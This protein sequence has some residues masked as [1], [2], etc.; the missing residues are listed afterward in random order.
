MQDWHRGL[1]AYDTR[2]IAEGNSVVGNVACHNRPRT[3]ESVFAYRHPWI[4]DAASSDGGELLDT[5]LEKFPFTMNFGVLVVGECHTWSDEHVVLDSHTGWDENE[6]SDLAIVAYCHAFLD[7]DEGVDLG[8]LAD[9]AA[10]KVY[11]VKDSG[12]GRESRLFDNRVLRAFPH[13]AGISSAR[14]IWTCT[15]RS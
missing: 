4:D 15:V 11:L 13:F 14:G 7:I 10:V 8:I 1:H 3:N 12:G 6:G 9:G 5:C 2:R